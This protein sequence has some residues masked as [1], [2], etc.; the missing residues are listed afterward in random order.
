MP[1]KGE[2][3]R[4]IVV[5]GGP[6]DGL[7]V[8]VPHPEIKAGGPPIDYHWISGQGIVPCPEDLNEYVYLQFPDQ[9]WALV[10]RHFTGDA[11]QEAIRQYRREHL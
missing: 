6:H 7:R 2:P 9:G 4:S 11:V 5:Y 8:F 1:P 10:S 3:R